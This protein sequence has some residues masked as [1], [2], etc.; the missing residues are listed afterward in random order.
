M[1][2]KEYEKLVVDGWLHI[3]NVTEKTDGMC[4]VMGYDEE[5]FYT[6]S[7]GSGNERMRTAID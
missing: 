1:K 2:D 6:Q 3:H 5:G 7:S 4:F